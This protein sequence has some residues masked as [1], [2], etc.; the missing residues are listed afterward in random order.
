MLKSDTGMEI[1]IEYEGSWRNSFLSGSNNEPLPKGGRKFIGSGASIKANKGLTV[2]EV[3]KST[4]LGVLSRLI[5]DQRKLYQA[6]AAP[7][8]YFADIEQSIDF[9][10]LVNAD[11]ATQELVYLRNY[12]KSTDQQSFTGVVSYGD[13]AKAFNDVFSEELWGMVFLSIDELH[14]HFLGGGTE[15]PKRNY[16]PMTVV[17]QVKSLKPEKIKVDEK[18]LELIA[19]FASLDEKFYPKYQELLGKSFDVVQLNLMG[20]LAQ[21]Q[22][23]KGKYDMSSASSKTGTLKGSVS[24]KA[25]SVRDFVTAY[26]DCNRKVIFGAPYIYKEK[27]AGKEDQK[28]TKKSGKLIIK[29]DVDDDRAMEIEMLIKCAGVSAFKVGKKGLAYIKEIR[30]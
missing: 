24:F 17:D 15:F 4:V 27:G 29:I 6:K 23:L 8:F 2:A 12:N 21:F 19:Y 3:T 18:S 30:V 5:G 1:E 28:L 14:A 20:L 7:N 22:R 16:C 9:V 25:L 26:S 10:D 11:C 13:K